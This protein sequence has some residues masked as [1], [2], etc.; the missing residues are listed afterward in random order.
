MNNINNINVRIELMKTS[1]KMY[2]LAG[3]LGISENTLLRRLRNELPE[4]T[5]KEY[6]SKI[7]EWAEAQ[8]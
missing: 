5:Q 7:R 1:M 6:I 4:E 8:K 2:Q 3:A